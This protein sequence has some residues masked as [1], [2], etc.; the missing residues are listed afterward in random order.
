MNKSSLNKL[1]ERNIPF[2]ALVEL[3]GRCNLFCS[4]CYLPIRRDEEEL[5]TAEIRTILEELAVAGTLFL[6]FSGGEVFLR[7][8]LFEIISYAKKLKFSVNI[9]T[10]GTLITREIAR[11]LGALSP[12]AVDISIYGKD[13]ETHD[14]I[15]SI[16]GSFQK[17]IE[18]IQLLRQEG[19]QVTTKTPLMKS[20]AAQYKDIISIANTLTAQ[21]EFY[22]VI[23]PGIDGS[24]G[25]L[26][27]RISEEQFREVFTDTLLNPYC[28]TKKDD[29]HVYEISDDTLICEAGRSSLVVSPSGKI[30]PCAVLRICYGD[31]R[32]QPFKEIWHSFEA[33]RIRAMKFRDLK[34]CTQCE[35]VAYC[36]RCPGIALIEHGDLFGPAE[37]FC[38]LARASKSVNNPNLTRKEVTT[39]L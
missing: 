21:Y 34:A 25:P 17:S 31:I 26:S 36:N 3:T 1:S 16:P 39:V 2:S 29:R 22:A 4:H 32:K 38:M 15:T 19:I 11:K 28:E 7:D 30:Y 14:A 6:T 8:D 20:N 12:H 37:F 24:R 5:T 10:N 18:A 33:T 27:H 13:S 35:L 23:S 9:L